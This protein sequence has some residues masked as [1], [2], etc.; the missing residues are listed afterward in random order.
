MRA[1][2][3]KSIFTSFRIFVYRT[4]LTLRWELEQ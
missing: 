3:I 4:D 1:S 2:R